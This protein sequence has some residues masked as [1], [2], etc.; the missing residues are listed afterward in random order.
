MN[1]LL[2]YKISR[3]QYLGRA[4]GFSLIEVVIAIAVLLIIAVAFV[5]MISGAFS[6]IFLAGHKAEAIMEAEARAEEFRQSPVAPQDFPPIDFPAG[7]GLAKYVISGSG[8]A[9]TGIWEW[10]GGQG[11]TSITVFVP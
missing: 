5:P 10:P 7:S 8:E 9:E 4:A 11:T 2:G 1:R 3:S 6:H